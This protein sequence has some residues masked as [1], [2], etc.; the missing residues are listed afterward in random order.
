MKVGV[1]YVDEEGARKNFMTEVADKDFDRVAAEAFDEWNRRLSKIKIEGGTEDEKT[2]FYTSLYH[3]M[4]DPR[5][6]S[7]ADGRYRAGDNSIVDP[8]G[9]YCR[10]TVFS[11]WDVFRS[12]FPLQTIINPQ[13]VND[14]IN[15]L[16]DLATETGKEYFE[17]WE[18]L[19]SYS[20]CMIGNPALSVIADSYAK[21]IRN[22]DA[23]LAL[24][25]AVNTSNRFGNA[26]QGYAPDGVSIS[27]TL[28]YAYAD[29]CAAQL[30]RAL[31]ADSLAIVFEQRAQAYRNV[32]NHDVGWF[33]PRNA[34]GTWSQWDSERSLTQEWF[35][36]IECNPYQQ[37]WLVPHDIDGL[38]SLIGSRECAVEMLDTLFA[39]T[40]ANMTWNAYYNHA[41]EPVHFVPFLYNRLQEPWKTQKQTRRI[42]QD[43]YFNRVEGLVGNED[44]G[45]MSAWYVLA[46]SG[47][48]P[49][50]PG[51]NR[52][53]ITSPVF[54]KIEFALDTE[55]YS[56]E[57]FTIV[58]HNNSSANIYID[59]ALLNGKEYNRCYLD[60]DDIS[61]GGSLELFMSPDPNKEWGK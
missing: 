35:G 53:E 55:Y 29:W 12:Q 7:D 44:A 11:G 32:F 36:C 2:V 19:N 46:S 21:G 5:E 3:T 16:I 1:S 13:V 37:G 23:P 57:K 47:L 18:L 26:K 20:G 22:F 50:C 30:A 24:R 39:K 15:S 48:H 34:D 17:R 54:D 38:V 10:R 27:N 56:G 14:Q 40:P 41:N 49:S 42:C 4:I 8:N 25:Y 28:E 59:H 45:Q 61:R 52:M 51:D 31:A 33:C 60:F 6:C 43:A 58:T 9:S